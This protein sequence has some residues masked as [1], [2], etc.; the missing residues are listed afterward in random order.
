MLKMDTSAVKCSNCYPVSLLNVALKIFTKPLTTRLNK[1][2]TTIVNQDQ[3][4][5]MRGREAAD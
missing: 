3:G 2:I 5:F 1:S 4:N